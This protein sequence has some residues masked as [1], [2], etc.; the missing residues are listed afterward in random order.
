M[1]QGANSH[2]KA[3]V[4]NTFTT[5]ANVATIGVKSAAL[6]S[7]VIGYSIPVYAVNQYEVD[8]SAQT[9]TT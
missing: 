5:N 3:L 4:D 7:S 2:I 6:V 8:E 9:S 1:N